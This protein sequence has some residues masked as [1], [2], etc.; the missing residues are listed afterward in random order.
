MNIRQPKRWLQRAFLLVTLALAS[1]SRAQSG[2]S[3]A[4]Q[5]IDPD[6]AA[7]H[8]DPAAL[9]MK[10][11]QFDTKLNAQIPLDAQF[12]DE[13]GRNVKLGDYFGKRPV[14]VAAVY[15]HCSMLCS[16]VI[17]S[18]LRAL[19]DVPETAGRDYDVVVISIDPRETSKQAMAEKKERVSQYE[20]ANWEGHPAAFKHANT[21]NGWHFLTG[22]KA[23]IDAYT[24]S[25]G[26]A[27][28]YDARTDEYMHPN[29]VVVV[30]PKGR[31]SRYFYGLGYEP[32]DMHLGLIESSEGHISTT[33]VEK[34]LL[35]CYH[36]DPKTGKY[37]AN[38]MKILR[39]FAIATVLGVAGY[40]GVSGIREKLRGPKT[41]KGGS[42]A[43]V[44]GA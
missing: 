20:S 36:Y 34:I 28:R 8:L 1:V 13:N 15:Y 43:V 4:P 25:V 10:E 12:R 6:A 24:H 29:G 22:Q 35:T 19:R 33:P 32:R 18:T 16:E 23:D 2:V 40:V 41:P 21:A 30:T 31:V 17:S 14:V 11:V 37:S 9:L 42:P 3:G 5:N 26:I 27:Y 44:P 38:L 39:L 7:G